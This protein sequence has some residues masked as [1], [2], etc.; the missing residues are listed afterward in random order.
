M[1]WFI[2]D[3]TSEPLPLLFN[4]PAHLG[5]VKSLAASGNVAVTGGSDDV[6]KIFDLKGKADMGTLMKH[7]GAVTCLKVCLPLPFFHELYSYCFL[8]L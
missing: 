1:T 8:A 6:I 4:Y 2:S 7:E 5:P 3:T